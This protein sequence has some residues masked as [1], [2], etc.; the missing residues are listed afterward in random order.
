MSEILYAGAGFLHVRRDV[1]LAIQK[2]QGL[3]M[4]NE[5][6]RLP[7]IP[8]F[9]SIVHACEDG[10]WYLAEDYAFCQRA[11]ASGF[12]IMAD[13]TVRLWHHGNHAYGWEDA[14]R[15]LERYDTFTLNLGPGPR[16]Q[17]DPAISPAGSNTPSGIKKQS[18]NKPNGDTGGDAATCQS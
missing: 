2:R 11:R 9:H 1:Y 13:T 4:C 5:R 18:K 8:F 17:S 6:F 7:M 16:Q 12:K 14:G 3:A 10:H 15:E